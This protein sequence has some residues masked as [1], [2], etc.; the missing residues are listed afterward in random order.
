MMKII[1]M[2]R[3]M[4][5]IYL[6]KC[7]TIVM[8]ACTSFLLSPYFVDAKTT[9]LYISPNTGIYPIGE[10]FTADIRINTG[11]LEIG[12]IDASIIY[13]ANDIEFVSVS[14]E[15]SVLSRVSFDSN[16]TKGRIDISGFITHGKPA[17]VGSDGLV[18]T[19]TFIP[20]HNVAT[21]LHFAQAAATPPLSLTASVGGLANLLSELS[22]ATYTL[23]PKESVPA[24]VAYA[25]ESEEFEITPLPVPPNDWFGTTSVKLSWS[26]PDRVTEMRTLLTDNQNDEP[27]KTYQVPVSSVTVDDLKE[28]N[29]Y[30]L[31]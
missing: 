26:L 14:D 11:G 23:I 20:L 18:A 2:I 15:S 12:T 1:L 3:R 30:F 21:E 28:G 9:S 25:S 22:A 17:Y 10:P 4:N 16:R 8:L 6:Y 7:V 13:N 5:N 29:N 31:L 27:N 19:I 24:A